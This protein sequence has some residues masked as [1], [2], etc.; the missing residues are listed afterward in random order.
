MGRTQPLG[1]SIQ[2]LPGLRGGS[3][4]SAGDEQRDAIRGLVQRSQAC[5]ERP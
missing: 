2:T 1:A 5:S 4:G 3:L